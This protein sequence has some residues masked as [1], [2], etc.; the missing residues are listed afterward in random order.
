MRIS[1]ARAVV[2]LGSH[3]IGVHATEVTYALKDYVAAYAPA[4]TE[5]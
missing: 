3:L 1:T 5:L 4:I 2:M